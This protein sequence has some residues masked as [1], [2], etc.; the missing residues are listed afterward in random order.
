[1]GIIQKLKV[2]YKAAVRSG[3]I[4][5]VGKTTDRNKAFNFEVRALNELEWNSFEENE[6]RFR[7]SIAS[8]LFSYGD[9]VCR[10][11]ESFMDQIN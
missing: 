1:M 9:F 4:V 5:F 8:K 10:G 3:K 6:I 2:I 7:K 11:N